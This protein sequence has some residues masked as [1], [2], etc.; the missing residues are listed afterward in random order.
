MDEATKDGCCKTMQTNHSSHF[1]LV[2]ELYPLLE[3]QAS[4]IGDARVVF[5]TSEARNLTEKKRLEERYLLKNGGNLG[6]NGK[7]ILFGG[8][9][10][11]RYSQSK[12]ANSVMTHAMHGKLQAKSSKIRVC[13]AHPGFALTGTGGYISLPPLERVLFDYYLIPFVMQSG[14][15]GTMGLL[16]GMMAGD[17][18]SGTLYGPVGKNNMAGPIVEISPNPWENDPEAMELLWT[19]SEEVT[20]ATFTI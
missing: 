12:L 14:E 4:A 10:I 6:G 11:Y 18:V 19:A 8:G 16:T 1:L 9:R 13:C 2:A 17:A 7:S 15:D 5:H 3:K 20:G